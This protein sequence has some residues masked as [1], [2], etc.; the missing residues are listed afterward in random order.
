MEELALSIQDQY[1]KNKFLL[2][3]PV[4][5]LARAAGLRANDVYKILLPELNNKD[6]GEALRFAEAGLRYSTIVDNNRLRE[7]VGE[8]FI[9]TLGSIFDRVQDGLEAK[10]KWI[11]RKAIAL[12]GQLIDAHTEKKRFIETVLVEDKVQEVA[13]SLSKVEEI[14]AEL[15]AFDKTNDL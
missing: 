13:E 9:Y 8:E 2:S 11:K 10:E 5:V 7:E 12:H 4:T 15:I 14:E 6:L 1:K 3:K